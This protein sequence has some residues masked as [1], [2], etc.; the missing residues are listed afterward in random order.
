[1]LDAEYSILDTGSGY[2]NRHGH[3][4]VGLEIKGTQY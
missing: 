2:G 1:M 3:G 4:K